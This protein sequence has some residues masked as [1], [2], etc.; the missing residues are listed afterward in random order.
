MRSIR[1]DEIE[2]IPIGER[3]LVWKPLR[4]ALGIEAF[5][6]N[7]YTAGAAG[8]EVVE[9]HDELGSGA[10]RHEELYVVVSGHAAFTV[11]GNEIDAPAGTCVFLSDPAERRGAIAREAGTVV[12]AVG[13]VPGEPFTISPWEYNFR[14]ADASRQGRHADAVAI[15]RAGLERHPGNASI[16]YN[17]AC[18]ESLAGD[19][20]AALEHLAEAAE[21]DARLREYAQTDPDLAA[22]R[23]DPRFPSASS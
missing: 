19:G 13:G 4:H 11:D 5:G 17:L 21:R 10:G 18:F 2:G 12:L 16:L 7:A 15:A 1:L 22:V 6:I 23:A 3:G 9:E 14:A 8:E 20:E